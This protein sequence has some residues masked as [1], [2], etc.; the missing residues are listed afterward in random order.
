TNY[1]DAV[2]FSPDGHTLATGSTDQTVRL[3]N[4]TNPAHPT[5]LG[6]PLSGHT[7]YVKAVAFSPDGHTLATGSSDQTVRLWGMS[8][9]QAIQRICAT[10]TN[11]LT[12]AE[13]EQYVSPDLPYR[14]PC[15]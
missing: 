15:R 9:D 3:W 5:P 8:V 13:W 12:P 4:I 7:N 1:V 10:T 11:T 14:P 2:A 6:R